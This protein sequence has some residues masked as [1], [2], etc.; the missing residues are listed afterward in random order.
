MPSLLTHLKHYLNKPLIIVRTSSIIS[1]I[2]RIKRQHNRDIEKNKPNF[3]KKHFWKLLNDSKRLHLKDF[4]CLN[5]FIK[6]YERI[7]KL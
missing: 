2:R 7:I 6:N 5:I 3:Y 1:M 4:M